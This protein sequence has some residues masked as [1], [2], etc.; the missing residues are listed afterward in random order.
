MPRSQKARRLREAEVKLAIGDWL[1]NLGLQV[2]DERQNRDRPK[3]GVFEIRKMGRKIGRGKRPDLVVRGNLIGAQTLKQGAWVPV[4]LKPGYKHH[5]ILNGFDAILDCFSDYLWGAEY[6]VENK[7]IEIAAFVFATLFSQQ[8]FLFEQE[9][10]FDP[11]GIVRGPWDAYPMTFTIS[12]LLWRQRDNLV[13]RFQIL[14][15][16]PKVET[17][18]RGKLHAGRPILEIGV[19]IQN[20][21]A[22]QEVR[23][24]LS[25]RPYHWRFEPE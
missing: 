22:E 5:D 1:T 14:S 20:P 6:W 3:W 2:F 4:E 18:L 17:K 19:L 12:R 13:K 9:G 24:M 7:P 10:K 21:I 16:I 25:E 15:G 11:R 23:L 8:G